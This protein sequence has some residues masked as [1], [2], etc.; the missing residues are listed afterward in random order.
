MV[1]EMNRPCVVR[2]SKGSRCAVILAAFNHAPR[3]QSKPLYARPWHAKKHNSVTKRAIMPMC[4]IQKLG[5]DAFRCCCR[6][7]RYH[8]TAVLVHVYNTIRSRWRKVLV[9]RGEGHAALLSA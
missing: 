3:S 5:T 1:D 9:G 4:A 6:K 7:G 2:V 8:A